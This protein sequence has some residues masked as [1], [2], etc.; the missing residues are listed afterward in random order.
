[1]GDWNF[2]CLQGSCVHMQLLNGKRYN[3]FKSFY[4][5]FWNQSFLQR[6]SLWKPKEIWTLKSLVLRSSFVKKLC[7]SDYWAD[8]KSFFKCIWVGLSNLTR[9]WATVYFTRMLHCSWQNRGQWRT[10]LPHSK[11]HQRIHH[12]KEPWRLNR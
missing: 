8:F 3:Y 1:M 2:I 10:K 5:W 6:W 12:V 11:D 4:C 7:Y 9:S